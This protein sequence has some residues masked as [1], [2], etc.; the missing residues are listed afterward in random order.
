MSAPVSLPGAAGHGRPGYQF[1]QDPI[2]AD[3]HASGSRTTGEGKG[4]SRR[5]TG[6]LTAFAVAALLLAGTAHASV[7]GF[8][9]QCHGDPPGGTTKNRHHALFVSGEYLCEACHSSISA[10]LQTDC[11]ICH[12]ADVFVAHPSCLTCHGN[13]VAGRRA[14][15]VD[16]MASS[17]HVQTGSPPTTADCQVCH[18][19]TSHMLGTV[20][21]RS[22]ENGS[23]ITYTNEASATVFCLACHDDNSKTATPFSDLRTPVSSGSN[24]DGKSIKI[25][26]SSTEIVSSNKYPPTVTAP[27]MGALY[28][29]VPNIQRAL[30][31][32]GNPGQN[33]ANGTASDGQVPCLACHNSH[34]SP[35]SPLLFSTNTYVPE[36]MESFCWDCHTNDPASP[37]KA[38]DYIPGNWVKD[39]F[40]DPRWV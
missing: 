35:V 14:V 31:A 40:G 18:V 36:N 5:K 15:G 34:G 1:D 29:T 19:T 23:T 32:H 39:Y 8:C 21:L 7:E 37:Q 12:G 28:N 20:S 2:T 10:P 22:A 27:N 16:F 3:P 30:S 25:K 24:W 6:M 11:T 33:M 17:R 26:Y 9:R 13:Q 4:M 38:S